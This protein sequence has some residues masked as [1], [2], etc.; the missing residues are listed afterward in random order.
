MKTLYL[1]RHAKSSWTESGHRDIDRPLNNR[2]KKTAPIMAERLM[3]E[4]V[5]LD[6]FVSSPAIRA[7][8]T[9]KIFC[10]AFRYPANNILEISNLYEGLAENYEAALVGLSDT[11]K[12]VAIFGHNP[13]ITYFSHRLSKDI[14]IDHFPTCGI[15]AI[16]F[17]CESWKDFM[18]APNRFL[19]FDYPKS[20]LK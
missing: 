19:F 14:Y 16:V 11:L 7:M 12:Q 1:I 17:F 4:N 5:K 10:S 8:E 13:G 3:K 20:I 6:L 15:Y 2:G 9:C 18:L